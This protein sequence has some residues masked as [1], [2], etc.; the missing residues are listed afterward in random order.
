MSDTFIAQYITENFSIE[1]LNYSDWDIT[2]P[3]HIT[4]YWSGERALATRHTEARAVWSDELL[5]IRFDCNQ[6]EPLVINN[7]PQTDTKTDKLW[8]FDV[9]EIFIAPNDD[10]PRRYFEFEVAPTGEW[11]DLAIHQTPQGR[12]TNWQYESQM[13]TSAKIEEN[14]VMMAICI[15]FSSISFQPKINMRKRA[16]LFRC[17]GSGTNRGY[18]AWQPTLTTTPNFHVPEAFGWIEFQQ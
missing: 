16:N 11:L 9:C 15:P 18:L 2:Q 8:E 7:A 17:V 4:R 12:E 10:E 3:I 14:R 13:I 6:A 5:Y 1:K